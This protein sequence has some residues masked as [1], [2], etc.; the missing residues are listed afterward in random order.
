MPNR[1]RNRVECRSCE[2]KFVLCGMEIWMPKDP[3]SVA[4]SVARSNARGMPKRVPIIGVRAGRC[5]GGDYLCGAI[6][7]VCGVTFQ[8][9]SVICGVLTDVAAELGYSTSISRTSPG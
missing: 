3:G 9:R 4:T 8:P 5:V 7:I 2:F 6:W 1:W